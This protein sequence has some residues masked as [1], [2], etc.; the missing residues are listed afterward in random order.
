MYKYTSRYQ[1]AF[2]KLVSFLTDIFDYN[3][4]NTKMYFSARMPMNI[5]IGYSF[6]VSKIQKDRKIKIIKLAERMLQIIK[7]FEFIKKKQK[8]QDNSPDFH[9]KTSLSSIK[10]IITKSKMS[11][12]RPQYALYSSLLNQAPWTKTKYSLVQIHTWCL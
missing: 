9:D 10:N 7:H 1:V 3:R 5:G 2:D 12:K 8:E 4:N 6:I 11:E